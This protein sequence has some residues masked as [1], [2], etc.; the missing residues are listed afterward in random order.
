M[1]RKK[2]MGIMKKLIFQDLTPFAHFCMEEVTIR[3]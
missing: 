2:G 3:V 1:E